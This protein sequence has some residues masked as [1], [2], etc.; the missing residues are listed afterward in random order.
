EKDNL[1][2]FLRQYNYLLLDVNKDSYDRGF[3]FRLDYETSGLCF[4]AKSDELYKFVR[5]HFLDVAKKQEYYATVEG[6]LEV[7]EEKRLASHLAP[8][9]ERGH[10]MRVIEGKE[11]NAF[12][13]YKSLAYCQKENISLLVIQLETGMR[14]QIRAQL[15][16]VGYPILGDFLY[17]GREAP[18]LFLH[19]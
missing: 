14:H 12:L 18:R 15:S 11:P 8:Y 5:T 6:K 7:G 3:L 2:V 9:G 19:A 10:L 17:G 16:S 1:L 4:Y 13:S